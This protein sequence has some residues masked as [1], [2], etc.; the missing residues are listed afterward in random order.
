VCIKVYSWGQYSR[1]QRIDEGWVS[2]YSMCVSWCVGGVVQQSLERGFSVL[3]VCVCHGVFSG[4][5]FKGSMKL[6]GGGFLR[7]VCVCHVVLPWE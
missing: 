2:A 7:I 3:E 4:S 1:G 6:W 5:I